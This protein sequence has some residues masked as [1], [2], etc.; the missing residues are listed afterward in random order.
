[1]ALRIAPSPS[2]PLRILRVLCVKAFLF[3]SLAHCEAT[4]VVHRLRARGRGV[5]EAAAG[6]DRLAPAEGGDAC[7]L[8]PFGQRIGPLGI[9]DPAQFPLAI[10]DE[11]LIS[12]LP[13]Q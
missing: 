6:D 2:R 3:F 13:H 5:A 1:M 9:D 8:V 4:S 7:A 12:R 11:P 10:L